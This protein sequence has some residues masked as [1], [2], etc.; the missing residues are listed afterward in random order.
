MIIWW[1]SYWMFELL[2]C[3]LHCLLSHTTTFCLITYNIHYSNTCFQTRWQHGEQQLDGMVIPHLT[4]LAE[5]WCN[6]TD[7]LIFCAHLTCPGDKSVSNSIR[8]NKATNKPISSNPNEEL[9]M[10][11]RDL[12][13]HLH[14]SVA[15]MAC[16]NTE[17]KTAHISSQGEDAAFLLKERC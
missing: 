12:K 15:W 16:T 14:S 2:A 5:N 6:H 10:L 4:A 9:A 8:K 3:C 13:V 7:L 17:P 1:W 11:V